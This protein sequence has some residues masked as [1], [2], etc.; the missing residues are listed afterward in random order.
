MTG[1][2]KT[3]EDMREVL[4]NSVA[5]VPLY[6]YLDPELG[7]EIKPL[8]ITDLAEAAATLYVGYKLGQKIDE[9]G[10]ALAYT[11]RRIGDVAASLSR[12]IDKLGEII[13][14]INRLLEALSRKIDDAFMRW[15]MSRIRAA[16]V[17]IQ[18]ELQTIDRLP[19]ADKGNAAHPIVAQCLAKLG[20]E[21]RNL[22]GAVVDYLGQ[23]P[24]YPTPAS[25]IACSPAI[26]LWA[27]VYT[28]MERYKPIEYRSGTRSRTPS[29]R[30]ASS[31][32]LT[33][34]QRIARTL[35]SN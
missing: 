30:K 31:R 14:A 20:D 7:Q 26:A 32:S 12:V 23:E 28:I 3:L 22:F 33:T 11:I 19:E 2:Q 27:Q 24:P 16:T 13:D 10:S 15:H 6:A 8:W 17:M 5:P 4:L 29:S 21:H 9:V 25:M 34:W 18:Q 1:D 35:R